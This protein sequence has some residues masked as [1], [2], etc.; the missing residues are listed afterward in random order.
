MKIKGTGGTGKTTKTG[1]KKPVTSADQAA[2]FS[3]LMEAHSAEGAANT[4]ATGATSSIAQVDVLLMA[5]GADDATHGGKQNRMKRR[6]IKI[7]DVLDDLR[8]KML[9]GQLTVGDMID[10]A[11]VV[12]SHR[13]NIDDPSLTALMDEV[14]LRAQVEIAKMTRALNAAAGK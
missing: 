6:A 8:M 9:G 1:S 7:L 5:Q 14:D 11:D 13:E 12:A 4:A 3:R 10:V 2:E